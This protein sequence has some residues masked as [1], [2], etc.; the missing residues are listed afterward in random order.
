MGGRSY[1]SSCDG[2]VFVEIEVEEGKGGWNSEEQVMTS[3]KVLWRAG[4]ASAPSLQLLLLAHSL[5]T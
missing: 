4:Q 2:G 1:R 5:L 3:V